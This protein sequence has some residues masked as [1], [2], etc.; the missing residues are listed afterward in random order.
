LSKKK[1]K[2]KYYVCNECGYESD[3]WFAKCP[4][5]NEMGSAVEFT[6]D[7]NYMDS[8]NDDEINSNEITYLDSKIEEPERLKI[9]S[10]QI[11]KALNEG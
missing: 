2:Q 4:I 10:I 5:C 7:I 6:A 8:S 9:K 11:N 1:A 3:K